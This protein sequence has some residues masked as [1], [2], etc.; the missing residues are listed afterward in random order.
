MSSWTDDLK[1]LSDPIAVV[2][3][4]KAFASLEKLNVGE[5]GVQGE[6][7]WIR[8]LDVPINPQGVECGSCCRTIDDTVLWELPLSNN[9]H[10]HCKNTEPQKIL[11]QKSG[12][13]CY[14]RSPAAT[15]GISHRSDKINCLCKLA[16]MIG[17]FST[18][19]Y[20]THQARAQEQHRCWLGNWVAA[21]IISISY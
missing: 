3:F 12:S 7:W 6:S 11:L 21:A 18:D 1:N 14:R 10:C 20:Q 13:V 19:G 4:G 17:A 9:V 8:H 16:I 15:Q 5:G 2:R